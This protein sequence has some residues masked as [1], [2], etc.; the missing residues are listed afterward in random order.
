LQM[1][2]DDKGS[3]LI[4][5]GV[6]GESS[7][8]YR[9]ARVVPDQRPLNGRCCCCCW[10]WLNQVVLKKRPLNEC[11][12]WGHGISYQITRPALQCYIG[13]SVLRE[14]AIATL[15][16]CYRIFQQSAHIA[17]F[18]PHKLAFW[19]AILIILIFFVFLFESMFSLWG[20]CVTFDWH[21]HW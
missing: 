15:F 12:C 5:I 2:K 16:T 19:M 7:F 8:W 10:C 9:P 6:S 13:M 20:L 11:C 3:T 1:E 21:K 4:R 17:Y 18:F 14:Y